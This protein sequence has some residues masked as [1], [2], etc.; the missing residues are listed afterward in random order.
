MATLK[1]NAAAAAGAEDKPVSPAQKAAAT[2]AAKKSVAAKPEAEAAPAKKAAKKAAPKVEK[3]GEVEAEP[4]AKSTLGKKQ[5][6]EGIR[7]YVVAKGFGLPS[8]LAEVVVE[9][10][11]FAVSQALKEGSDVRL[12]LGKF[13]AQQVEART[14]RNPST[15]EELQVAAHVA[16]K[17]KPSATFKRMLNGGSE[18][19]AA[20]GA[21]E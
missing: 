3:T 7:A 20:E 5:V 1:K 16:P 8:K 18:E 12:N 6:A 4:V 15:G 11:E 14:G 2:K 17:F 10:F 19:V 9:G 13:F 21:A